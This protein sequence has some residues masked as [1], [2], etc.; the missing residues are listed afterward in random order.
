MRDYPFQEHLNSVQLAWLKKHEVTT[1]T[2]QHNAPH[3]S[4]TDQ[5]LLS[6]YCFSKRYRNLVKKERPEDGSQETYALVDLT[7]RQWNKET[8]WKVQLFFA[9]C[10]H[11]LE[12]EA[13]T[14]G[15]AWISEPSFATV[16]HCMASDASSVCGI[17]FKEWCSD[18]G[19]NN[20]SMK[21]WATYNACL[22]VMNKL[23]GM[24]GIVEAGRLMSLEEEALFEEFKDAKTYSVHARQRKKEI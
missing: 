3:F 21:H 14:Q 24:F 19:W 2:I 6:E 15:S 8:V 7:S 10:R 20:D 17:T 23:I 4:R 11:P 9:R 18:L 16:L 22:D 12:S 1:D 13:F 5:H